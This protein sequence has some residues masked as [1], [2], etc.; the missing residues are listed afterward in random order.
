MLCQADR[1]MRRVLLLLVPVAALAT[2]TATGPARGAGATGATGAPAWSPP[3]QLPKWSG[4]EPSVAIDPKDASAVYVSAPQ[5]I[6][7]VLNQAAGNTTSGS[8]GVGFW[9]SHDGGKTFPINSNIASTNG[10][11]DSDVE[12]GLDHTVYVADLEAVTTDLCT[13]ND[14]GKTFTAPTLVGST[15]CGPVSGSHQGPETDREWITRGNNGEL[16]L[17]YHDFAGGLPI[18]M[19]STDK[20]KSFLPCGSILDPGGAAGQ[21]YS[22]VAGTLVPKPVIGKDGSVYVEVTEPDQASPPI[23]ANLTHLFMTVGKGGCNG[24]FTNH[25]IYSDPGASFGKIF[26]NQAVDGGDVLYVVAA[27]KSRAGQST[28][29]LWL[30]TSHDQGVTWSPP[31][32]VNTP[33][34]KANAMPAIAGGLA[35]DQVVLGWFGSTNASDPNDTKA[36]WRYYGATS[37]DGGKTFSQSVVT[38]DVIHYGDICTQGVFCGLIPGQ[39]SNRNL[40]DFSSAA[41]DPVTGCA[42]L[43]VPGDPYNRPDQ[44]N[45]PN[46]FDSSAYVSRQVGGACLAAQT[47]AGGTA[48]PAAARAA[49]T[50]SGN[51]APASVGAGRLPATG[52]TVPAWIALGLATAGLAV[53]GLRRRVAA[54]QRG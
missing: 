8:N 1:C 41:V 53:F 7:A 48:T 29:N 5:H 12:V 39:P 36:Q 35:K 33:D 26:D 25:L 34:L 30:F 27:G 50:P 54:S 10:G 17:T 22:P 16:Y 42:I 47:T 28:T 13:S 19:K 4:S 37:F 15:P 21:N 51:G 46:T 6:P 43:V 24:V 38:P 23:G 32:Q 45:G 44:T 11:G 18:I 52:G 40:A 49:A 14:G 31:I 3:L 2:L 20:A 9:A